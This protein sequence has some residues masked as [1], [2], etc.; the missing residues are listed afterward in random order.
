MLSLGRNPGQYIVI[1][2]RIIVQVVSI[3]GEL[4]LAIDAP[5]EIR[6]ERGEVYEKTHEIPS[7]IMKNL[8]KAKT[9]KR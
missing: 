9:N 1:D 8:S 2:D 3:G 7:S 6:I 4:R 5:K